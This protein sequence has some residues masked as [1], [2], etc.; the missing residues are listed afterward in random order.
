MSRPD[1][2]TA[3]DPLAAGYDATFTNTRIGRLLRDRVWSYVDPL[4]GPGTRVLELNCGTGEDAVH[5]AARGA[6]VMATDIAAEMVAVTRRKADD[7][8]VGERVVTAQVAIESL[9][10]LA[11]EPFDLVL[12]NFGGLNCVADPRPLGA[13]LARLVRPGGIAVLVVMG[14]VVPW[15]WGWFLARRRP[16]DAVRRL[17]GSAT[18][19]GATIR[20]PTPRALRRAMAP[21]WTAVRAVPIGIALPPS[22]AES[23]VAHRPRLLARLDRAEGGLARLPGAA[24]LGDHYLMQLRRV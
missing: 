7:R 3:F 20:Y 23:F 21:H 11:A 1:A 10:V 14:P 18:W 8:G 24:W 17:R 9:D 5:L 4:V 16:R 2:A 13:T 6:D 19:R 12:S 22:Y 15:E